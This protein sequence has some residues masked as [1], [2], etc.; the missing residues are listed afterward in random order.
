[1]DIVKKM[2]ELKTGFRGYDKEAVHTFIQEILRECEQDKDSS[3]A[4]LVR[5]NQTLQTEVKES[6][7]RLQDIKDQNMELLKNMNSMT[8]AVGKGTDY[9]RERDRE[10]DEYRK[11]E[12]DIEELLEKTRQEAQVEHD[13]ILEEVVARKNSLLAD[14]EAEKAELLSGARAEAQELVRKARE[15]ADRL[16]QEAETSYQELLERSVRVRKYLDEM[17]NR[18]MLLFSWEEEHLDAELEEAG[19]QIKA[20]EEP[21]ME[22]ENLVEEQDAE[23]AEAPEPA[24]EMAA[25]SETQEMKPQ[26]LEEAVASA[27]AESDM[28]LKIVD[29]SGQLPIW[30]DSDELIVEP[31]EA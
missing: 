13:R 29:V 17:K 10:L 8:E 30:S 28:M 1:M 27:R 6:K 9:T 4:E 25:E 31:H 5:Q 21:D 14:V 18:M 23:S 19:V 12:K 3:M 24:E 26:T 22:E 15:E 16:Q 20:S 2:E 11:K 7:E